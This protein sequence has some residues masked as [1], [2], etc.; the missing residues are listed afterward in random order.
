MRKKVY[1]V[2][3]NQKPRNPFTSYQLISAI[4]L[5]SPLGMHVKTCPTDKRPMLARI[6]FKETLHRVAGNP[7]AVMNNSG[8]AIVLILL[9]TGLPLDAI[10]TEYRVDEEKL[11]LT[12]Y[13]H[14]EPGDRLLHYNVLTGHLLVLY[15][16]L[17]S[18]WQ[19]SED[20]RSDSSVD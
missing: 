13:Q 3:T 9:T 1:P 6:T 10:P 20:R 15:K 11:T 8:D 7:E 4:Q 16:E 14:K 18:Y 2:P 5:F 17:H 12:Y 19:I